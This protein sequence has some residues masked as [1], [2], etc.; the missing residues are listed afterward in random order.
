MR[1][2]GSFTAIF[3]ILALTGILSFGILHIARSVEALE[4]DRLNEVMLISNDL[5]INPG[6][7]GTSLDWTHD[8]VHIGFARY[9]ESKRSVEDHILSIEKINAVSAIPIDRI[10]EKWGLETAFR[11]RIYSIGGFKYLD[12]GNLEDNSSY[13]EIKR[14]AMIEKGGEYEIVRLSFALEE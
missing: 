8:P 7:N 13:L 5:L 14:L 9:S 11:I 3:S 1:A 2:Q 6:H 4:D 12:L 10:A